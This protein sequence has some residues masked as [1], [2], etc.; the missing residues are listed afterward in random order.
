[1]TMTHAPARPGPLLRVV[2]AIPFI[3]RIARDIARDQENIWYALVILLT[4]LV[5]SVQTWGVVALSVAALS[6]VPVIFVLLI[7][8]TLG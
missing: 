5:L 2:H 8:I 7:L 3:G 1:M 4:I 6:A